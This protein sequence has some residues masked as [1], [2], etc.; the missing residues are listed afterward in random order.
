MDDILYLYDPSDYFAC[1]ADGDKFDIEVAG[2]YFLGMPKE[3]VCFALSWADDHYEEYGVR[4]ISRYPDGTARI[5]LVELADEP[6][7]SR[8]LRGMLVEL[9]ADRE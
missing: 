5:E 4:H 6:H 3:D 8:F 2:D 9:N 7:E 1:F